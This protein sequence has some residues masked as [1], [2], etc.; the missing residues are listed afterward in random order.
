MVEYKKQYGLSDDELKHFP[1]V[2]RPGLFEGQTALVSG[3]S[4][5]IGFALALAFLRLGGNVAICGRNA[6]RLETA[7]EKLSAFGTVLAV[8]MTIRE[9]G[10]VKLLFDAAEERFGGVNHLF[11][12][13]G[14]HFPQ[15]AIDYSVNG[16]KAVIDTNLNGTWFMTQEAARR[17]IKSGKPGSVVNIT[18]DIWR[19]FP[20]IAHSCAA[21]A[22]VT[23]LARS[24]AVE[25]APHK[26]RVNCVAPGVIETSGFNQYDEDGLK[27]VRRG[28]PML[29]PG[30]VMDIVEACLYLTGPAG[31]FITG[32]TL[33]VDGGQQMWGDPWPTGRPAYFDE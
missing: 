14:G 12:N 23:Y 33:T 19:G 3:G 18:L 16:W 24:L 9:P 31:S 8:P 10:E 2:Y 29:K 7:R 5:G 21:R 15:A 26:I 20:G 30:T 6:D 17:W 32:E 1:L 25:W 4:T 11:N 27:S 22:G 28:N 13:G